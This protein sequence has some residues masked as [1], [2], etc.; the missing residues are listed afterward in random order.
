MLARVI[1]HKRNASASSE[2][3]ERPTGRKG[4]LRDPQQLTA[5]HVLQWKVDKMCARID[6]HLVGVRHIELADNVRLRLAS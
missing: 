4:S 2:A 5:I 3:V 6:G 1:I